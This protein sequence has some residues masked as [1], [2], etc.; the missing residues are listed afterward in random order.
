MLRFHIVEIKFSAHGAFLVR[1]KSKDKIKGSK[2]DRQ[3][4]LWSP[5]PEGGEL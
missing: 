2:Q 1:S 4:M 3:N 5:M